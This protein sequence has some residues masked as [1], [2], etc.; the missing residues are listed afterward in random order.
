M[1]VKP[2][3]H[4]PIARLIPIPSGKHR[5]NKSLGSD[6]SSALETNSVPDY[7]LVNDGAQLTIQNF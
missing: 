7:I 6:S 3:S 5:L 1:L 2:M 4:N